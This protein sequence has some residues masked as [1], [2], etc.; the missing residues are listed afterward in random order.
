M[1]SDN[2]NQ[3]GGG[4]SSGGGATSPAEEDLDSDV[5]TIFSKLYDMHAYKNGSKIKCIHFA[6][7]LCINCFYFFRR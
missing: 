1:S 2:V 4:E 7:N 3:M 5:G 6:V